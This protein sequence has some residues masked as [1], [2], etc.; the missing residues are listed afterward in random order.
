MLLANRVGD[1]ACRPIFVRAASFYKIYSEL[2]ESIKGF[3]NA[4]NSMVERIHHKQFPAFEQMLMS[5][6][7]RWDKMKHFFPD[8]RMCD[9]VSSAPAT[10]AAAPVSN[11]GNNGAPNITEGTESA[12]DPE[13]V[14]GDSA[15][16]SAGMARLVELPFPE[17]EKITAM[18]EQVSLGRQLLEDHGKDLKAALE[19]SL[20]QDIKKL[21]QW[22]GGL[23]D[24]KNWMANLQDPPL[25]IRHPT[26]TPSQ[27]PGKR[28]RF[29][30]WMDNNNNTSYNHILLYICI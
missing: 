2:V 10:P 21:K 23:P 13:N 1:M 6:V 16:D 27:P 3:Q 30:R 4:G 29:F 5:N 25:I 28:S 26:P 12:E 22:S 20:L 7:C 11:D 8:P 24:G 18:H 15:A 9:A 14:N 19:E 17:P